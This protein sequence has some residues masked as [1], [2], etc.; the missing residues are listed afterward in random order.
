MSQVIYRD[1]YPFLL[2][3]INL[4]EMDINYEFAEYIDLDL[5]KE[6]AFEIAFNSQA[7][8]N[9]ADEEL[10]SYTFERLYKSS[11]GIRNYMF[12]QRN[13]RISAGGDA[14]QADAYYPKLLRMLV[15]RAMDDPSHDAVYG[16]GSLQRIM[17]Q[18]AFQLRNLSSQCIICL[19]PLG[20]SFNK[21]RTCEA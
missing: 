3:T 19:K 2:I 8:I 17:R 15:E 20:R 13:V 6:L 5:T 11:S 16:E 18:I 10:D 21:M 12:Y 9:F 7:M 4:M 1:N 14:T